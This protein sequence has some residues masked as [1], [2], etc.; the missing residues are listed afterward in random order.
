MPTIFISLY[1]REFRHKSFQ[2]T[3]KLR[4]HT[5]DQ[6]WHRKRRVNYAALGHN[7]RCQSVRQSR[8]VGKAF[9]GEKCNEAIH[10]A[11]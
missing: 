8:Q 9:R 5:N 10:L 7:L 6:Y 2:N 1:C 11:A 3:L 4:S